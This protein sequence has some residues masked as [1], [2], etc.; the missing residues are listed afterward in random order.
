LGG[1]FRLRVPIQRGALQ[2]TKGVRYFLYTII[3]IYSRKV[4]GWT[5]H[6]ADSEKHARR[7]IGE[8]CRRYGVDRNQLVIHADRGSPMIAG[9]VAELLNELGVRKS[10]SRPRVSNGNP[11]IESHFKTLEYRPDYPE[12]FDSINHA[13][14]WCR[15]FFQRYNEVHHH[16]GIAYLRPADLRDGSHTVI[17]EHRQA[18]LDAAYQPP[19]TIHQATP[20][21]RDSAKAWINKPTI[22]TGQDPS[23]QLL[24][25]SEPDICSLILEMC[26]SGRQFP[27]G[28][29]GKSCQRLGWVA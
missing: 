17:L 29:C 10:H 7:L 12:R 16:S 26:C 15:S 11:F 18:A 9:T 28:G 1:A 2:P 4:V 3:G 6:D 24:T 25:G 21:A 5:M 19:R 27:M 13:R 8:V 20:A 23:N 14:S 22:Q